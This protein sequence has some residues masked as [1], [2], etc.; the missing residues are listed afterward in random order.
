MNQ[1]KTTPQITPHKM[2]RLEELKRRIYQELY[3]DGE[4]PAKDAGEAFVSDLAE[5]LGIE[6]RVILVAISFGELPHRYVSSESGPAVAV[7]ISEARAWLG[8]QTGEAEK[9]GE[10]VSSY[11]LD[12]LPIGVMKAGSESILDD[13]N[14]FSAA[15]QMV[16]VDEKE[17]AEAIK[18]GEVQAF[19][20]EMGEILVS[21]FEVA[22]WA[23]LGRGKYSVSILGG[24]TSNIVIEAK[25]RTLAKQML[26]RIGPLIPKEMSVQLPVEDEGSKISV[27]VKF[28]GEEEY[29]E[30]EMVKLPEQGE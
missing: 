11:L 25:S 28:E 20:G 24:T 19:E 26:S 17:L 18:A 14:P 13:L 23:G 22:E 29:N 8:R 9:S 30:R 1:R 12:R 3:R 16:G 7:P 2:E 10:D 5:M 21:G 27:I 6:E 4:V 15:C